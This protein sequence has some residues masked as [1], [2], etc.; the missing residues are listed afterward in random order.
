MVTGVNEPVAEAEFGFQKATADARPIV[1]PMAL[2]S[3]GAEVVGV[4]LVSRLLV[5]TAIPSPAT[6]SQVIRTASRSGR[7]SLIR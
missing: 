6:R 7:L 4:E 2:Y 3:A 5:K 1:H